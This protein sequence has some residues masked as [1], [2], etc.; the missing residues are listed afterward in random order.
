VTRGFLC[1]TALLALARGAAAQADTTARRDTLAPRDTVAAPQDS[2]ARRDSVRRADTAA[3]YLPVLAAPRPSGPLPAGTRYSFPADSFVFS[4]VQTLSDLLGHIPGVYVARGGFYGQAEIVF[5]G[6]RGPAG[7]EVYWDGVPYLPLGRDSVYLDPARIPLAPLERVD[8]VVLPAA[9]RVYLVTARQQSTATSSQVRIATGQVSTANYRGAY[10]RRWRSGVGLS[11]VAD[12]NNNDGIGGGAS[13]AFNS[14][15]LWL[16]GEYLPSP[17]LGVSYQV[18]SSNWKRS[19]SDQGLTDHFNYQRRDGI[20]RLFAARRDDGLGPRVE[21]AFATATA[22]VDT[23][24]PA[25]S[26]SQGVV[27]FGDAWGHGHVDVTFRS[28][29]EARPWQLE[30]SA[31]WLPLPQ[32]AVAAD[33]RHARYGGV[34]AGDRAHV[35]AGLT[36]P[37]GLSAHGDLVW[38]RDLAAPALPGD[39]VQHTADV[40]AALRWQRRRA[41]VEFAVVRQDAFVPL[42]RPA[43]L[44]FFGTLSP[45]PATRCLSVSAALEPLTGLHLAGWYFNPLRAGG[46][47]FAPPYHARVSAA[48]YSKFWRQYRSGIFAFRAEAAMESWT[49]GTGGR[50]TAGAVRVLGGATFLE[51]NVEVQIAGV[52]IF[53]VQRNT[54]AMRAGYTPGLDYPRRYQYYGVRWLFTN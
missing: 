13:T 36:L 53:W 44:K 28:L 27:A 52:T 35:A 33:V 45:T 9:L 17:R 39:T 47:D 48:F 20:L 25:R 26:L 19:P 16:K 11:L 51:T 43:G 24:V 8:V 46:N 38:A 49:R 32:L 2:V 6:G 37:L 15:D 5:Y 18:L 7:L 30:A 40:S 4:N 10:L 31:A 50:D 29:D 14:V 41:V 12:Y 23:A 22:G 21:L 54:N 1:A 3:A 42:G 34:R